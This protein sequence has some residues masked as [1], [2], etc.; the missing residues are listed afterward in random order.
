M[1]P[2]LVR[3]EAIDGELDRLT[4]A[5][6]GELGLLEIGDHV[7]RIQRHHRHELGAGLDIL[8]DPQ[9]ARTDGAVDRCGNLRIGQVERRL[10]L[11]RAGVPVEEFQKFADNTGVLSDV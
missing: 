2:Q 4:V 11:D 5:H 6:M 10:L 9:G 8:A 1:A 3:L 7:D